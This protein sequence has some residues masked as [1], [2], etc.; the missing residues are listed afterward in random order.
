MNQLPKEDHYQTLGCPSV[1]VLMIAY[2]SAPYISDAIK[3]ILKQTFQEFEFIIVNDGSTDGTTEL[4]REFARQDLR[5]RAIETEN[6]GI[7]AATNR[8]LVE[9]HGRYIAIMDSDDIAEPARLKAQ[10]DFLE[11]HPDIAGVGSQWLMIDTK[12]QIV[13]LD[14]HPT[15]PELVEVLMF[16]FFCL[17][18]PTIMIRRDAL[19]A[20]GGYTEDRA[21]LVPDYDVFLRLILS[22][23][24]LSN[25]PQVLFRWRLNPTGTT[26]GKAKAQTLSADL[27][28]RHAFQLIQQK[29]PHRAAMI[30]TTVV[31]A[32]PAG[33]CF[34]KRIRKVLPNH[35][36]N[37]LM[38]HWRALSENDT[39][40]GLE[41]NA[42]EW[43]NNEAANVS[44][45]AD[46]L[47]QNNFPWLSELVSKKAAR[48]SSPV[49]YSWDLR[50]GK[51]GEKGLLSVL[52]PIGSSQE[53]LLE[54]LSSVFN[55]LSGKA[56]ILVFADCGQKLVID[57]PPAPTGICLRLLYSQTSSYQCPWQEALVASKGRY[58]AYLEE[59]CR[60]DPNFI[61]EG[62]SALSQ[63]EQIKAVFAPATEFFPEALYKGKPIFDPAPSPKWSKTTLI[64][65]RKIYLS[66]FINERSLLQNVCVPL[67]E[68]GEQAPLALAM[69]LAVRR[70]FIVLQVRNSQFI[71]EITLENRVL[72]TMRSGLIEWYFDFGLGALPA[73]EYWE[74]LTNDQIAQIE[75]QLSS[76]WVAGGLVICRR[77]QQIIENFFMKYVKNAVRSPLYRYLIC[78]QKWKFV[79]SLWNEGQPIM[80]FQ[81]SII[82]ISNYM[83][84]AINK[85]MRSMH[86]YSDKKIITL[87]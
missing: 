42:I 4:I 56:E 72:Q 61:G 30:A 32:F 34:D 58:L 70:K 83:E 6:R 2:N 65:H 10:A 5:I 86:I 82:I 38:Q 81:A 71:P 18:H 46:N 39:A 57:L 54:R 66:G 52:I 78:R 26:R 76:S 59:S 11:S 62:L 84:R 17:H 69:E 51:P 33:T 44:Q 43:L 20:A 50:G 29:E 1:S 41:F 22:G 36:P 12:G 49:S 28:R 87:E 80:A 48:H 24:K 15:K 25:L 45:L 73:E 31:K 19:L 74:N 53:D 21:C 75:N 79:Q 35:S 16:A 68:V 67:N 23:F 37:P 60:F 63:N 85:L 40:G 8:G 13:G 7:G 47:L 3:S 14:T 9:C 27:V 64:G 77:N 55:A